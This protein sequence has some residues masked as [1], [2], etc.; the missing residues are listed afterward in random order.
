MLTFDSLVLGKKLAQQEGGDYAL[1]ETQ[2]DMNQ[3]RTKINKVIKDN[4]IAMPIT[5]AGIK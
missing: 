2:A 5:R 1:K 3:L 4:K